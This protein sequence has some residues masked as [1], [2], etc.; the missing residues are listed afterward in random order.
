M[1]FNIQF[2][3]LQTYSMVLSEVAT[4]CNYYYAELLYFLM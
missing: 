3:D 1:Y 4:C 2:I